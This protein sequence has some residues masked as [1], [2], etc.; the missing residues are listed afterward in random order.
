MTAD[1]GHGV[2]EPATTAA[3]G[4]RPEGHLGAA[5]P[6]PQVV[7]NLAR[8]WGEADPLDLAGAALGAGLDGVTLADSPR[9]FPDCLLET[10]RILANTGA[11]L[12]GPCVLSLGLRHPA[13]VAGALGT[14]AAH[15]PGRLLAVV[16]RGESSVRNEGLAV[17][18]LR[19]HRESL[20]RL[21]ELL[22]DRA[23]ELRL[24]GAASGPRTIRATAAR[25]GGVLVDVGADPAVLGKAVRLVRA[26][27]PE[28]EIWVFLRAVL[29]RTAAEADAAGR[30]VLGSCASRLVRAPD[31]YDLPAE[32]LPRVEAVAAAH[33]YRRHGTPAA[34]GGAGRSPETER[35]VRDRFL[36]TGDERRI[37][38]QLAAVRGLG[39][40]GVVLAGALTGVVERLNKLATAVRA[41]LA[42]DP[43][44]RTGPAADPA[45]G[46]AVRHRPDRRGRNLSAESEE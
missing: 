9:L 12:A 17:P 24:L 6:A 27:R 4:G 3:T 37:A 36:L 38:G 23:P 21:R 32:L 42:I 45:A 31:W 19:T 43:A 11:R 5:G 30:P 25:L 18:S 39:V 40:D 20:D 10:G 44:V 41:G 2:P 29:T 14:L 15:H 13:T 8:P 1:L 16:G 22:D 46:P 35:L 26:E 28:A 7:L 34:R 33:D